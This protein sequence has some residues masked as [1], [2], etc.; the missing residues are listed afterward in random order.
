MTCI[1]GISY[2]G[3]V[4]M[5][6]ERGLSDGNVIVSM[7]RPKVNIKQDWVFGYAGDIG[8]GQFLNTIDLPIVKPNDDPYNLIIDNIIYSLHEKI[9]GFIKNDE[10]EADFLIGCQ[11]RLFE[12]NTSSWGVAEVQES[13]IGSGSSYAFGSLYTSID[14]EPIERIGLAIGAAITYSPTCQGP[15]DIIFI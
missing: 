12:L 2:K 3:N 15:V 6:G 13:S 5:G 8:I 10:V 4:Y 11:G 1:V 9:D 14:K 7:S